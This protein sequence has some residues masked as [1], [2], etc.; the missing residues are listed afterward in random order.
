MSHTFVVR[1]PEVAAFE[2]CRREW[3]YVARTRSNLLPVESPGPD[4]GRA[5]LEALA[6]YY[7]PAMDDW[8]RTIVRPLAVQALHRALT[9]DGAAG[10]SPVPLLGERLLGH[11]F[12]WA[13][14]LDEWD[15]LLSDDEFWSPVPDP[16]DPTQGLVTED[17]SPVRYLGRIDQLV[18][19]LDDEFWVVRHRMVHGDFA[20][21][22]ALLAD[23]EAGAH[24]W[25]VEYS[26]PHIKISGTI[27]N[28]LRLDPDGPTRSLTPD[29]AERDRRD[30]TAGRHTT[31]RKGFTTPFEGDV[32]AL[33]HKFRDV[34]EVDAEDGDDVFRRT[35]VRRSRASIATGIGRMSRLTREMTDAA[36]AVPPNPDV[37]CSTCAYL[38]PCLAERQDE[39]PTP[40]LLTG[41]RVR[42][43]EETDSWER[44][45]LQQTDKRNRAAY[46]GAAFR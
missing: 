8:S 13:A 23:E 30:M 19:D 2:R 17:G 31:P 9:R 10:G 33:P 5:L 24:T 32:A 6:V 20:G 3:D 22:E 28:E 4:L 40:L 16:E 1:A 43:P 11:Y 14:D 7:L 41:Y 39:D 35:R 29:A 12:A 15:S 18:A 26:Y 38:A 21:P 34:T 37:H 46:G 45:L 42:R 25:A 36:V 27:Y 44:L